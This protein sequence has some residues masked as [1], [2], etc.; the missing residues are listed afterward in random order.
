[1]RTPR[2]VPIFLCLPLHTPTAADWED[3]DS[4]RMRRMW[5]M[6]SLPPRSPYPLTNQSRL[7]RF[8]VSSLLSPSPQS[9]H[10]LL[11][12]F[13]FRQYR[14][15]VSPP[16]LST[17]LRNWRSD[18]N[19]RLRSIRTLLGSLAPASARARCRI[20]PLATFRQDSGLIS[21]F[22]WAL[23]TRP[24]HGLS[25]LPSRPPRSY[26]LRTVYRISKSPF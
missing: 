13:P 24:Y 22:F 19:G 4:G 1:M 6:A 17:H 11:R 18:F 2:P 14:A 23:P 25:P 3:C 16:S 10:T 5:K 9:Q 12:H 7:C 15:Y 21:A 26:P 8:K 20:G